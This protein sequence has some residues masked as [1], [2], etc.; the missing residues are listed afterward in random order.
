MGDIAAGLSRGDRGSGRA[1]DREPFER[2]T[3]VDLRP[4]SE[5]CIA[6]PLPGPRPRQRDRR[7]TQPGLIPA[8]TRLGRY[9]ILGELARGGMGQVLAG[10]DP[11]LKR[12][13]ALKVLVEPANAEY[14]ARFVREARLSARLE[15][16]NL[17]PVHDVGRTP[18][19]RLYLVMKRVEGESLE[20]I[21]LRLGANPLAS[22]ASS[23]RR[24]LLLAF[25]QICRAVDFAHSRGVL[26]RDI[27]PANI[28][29]GNFGEALLL[30]WGLA[31]EVGEPDVEE[32]D[33]A[34]TNPRAILG[35]PG[36]LSP[37]QLLQDDAP[38]AT[39]DIWGLG[40]VLY[41]ILTLRKAFDGERIMDILQATTRLP[42]DPRDCGPVCDEL[43]ELCM[44]ALDPD[45]EARPQRAGEVAEAIEAALARGLRSSATIRDLDTASQACVKLEQ[46]CDR[47]HLRESPLPPGA[48]AAERVR[49]YGAVQGACER[50]LGDPAG[51]GEARRIL[52]RA[53]L[54][55]FRIAVEEGARGQLPFLAERIRA[56]DRDGR[57]EDWLAEA[58]AATTGG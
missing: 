53:E 33:V 41:E 5:C 32:P 26:H 31:R 44:H 49:L 34:L 19:G 13:V 50:V 36:Y 24:R 6:E 2:A 25:A 30:D 56:L 27:K 17:V 57:Y 11:K 40:A 1:A 35:T 16:P 52:A 8:R 37:E 55:R 7:F 38:Q 14:A 43:A 20:Q 15:H 47:G 12:A 42:Q 4:T 45:P 18:E 48:A 58:L 3:D 39:A 28:M 9:E 10:W 22:D 23:S 29:L 21:L 51:I 54:S 46:L